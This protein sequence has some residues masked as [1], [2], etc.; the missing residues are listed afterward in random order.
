MQNRLI[1]FI[2]G[3]KGIWNVTR[4]ESVTGNSIVSVPMLDVV[5][6]SLSAADTKGSWVLQGIRSNERYVKKE[7]QEILNKK[8]PPLDRPESNCAALIPI[9]KSSTWWDLSQEERRNIF[10]E[11]SHHIMLGLDYLPAIARRLYHCRD[12]YEEAPFDF[13]TWF[14]YSETD[15]ELFEELVFNLRKTEEWNYVEREI[16]IRLIK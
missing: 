11:Q 6:G 7:E 13:L 12:L 16:D 2:G 9:K 5:E 1:N 4:I 3:D 15:S 14:E 10:E 8:S